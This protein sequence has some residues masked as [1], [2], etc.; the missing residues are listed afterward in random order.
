MRSKCIQ[1]VQNLFFLIM[2]PLKLL[3]NMACLYLYGKVCIMLVASFHDSLVVTCGYMGQQSA[4]TMPFQLH[5]GDT[6]DSNNPWGVSQQ[7][8]AN[9]HRIHMLAIG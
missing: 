1:L 3:W 7:A 2:H 5:A 9:Q 8:P 4:A 6:A